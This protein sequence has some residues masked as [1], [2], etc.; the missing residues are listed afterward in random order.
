MDSN[1]VLALVLV[2]LIFGAL[3]AAMLV[4]SMLALSIGLIASFLGAV[5]GG[6]AKSFTLTRPAAASVRPERAAVLRTE[7]SE[8]APPPERDWID[9]WFEDPADQP[10]LKPPK[11]DLARRPVRRQRPVPGS[12]HRLREVAVAVLARA[13]AAGRRV[14]TGPSEWLHLGG[15]RPVD[16]AP[17][18]RSSWLLHVGFGAARSRALPRARRRPRGAWWQVP[19]RFGYP[20]KRAS[21]AVLPK[22]KV[23]PP[24][25]P[26]VVPRGTDTAGHGGAAARS[27]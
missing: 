12:A 14:L 2:A 1:H 26:H 18:A 8:G 21:D 7:S 25:L 9:S 5:V 27:A 24:A 11:W 17:R 6:V 13:V 3:T 10:P 23:D 16:A 4:V 19:A 15:A 22:G 20:G